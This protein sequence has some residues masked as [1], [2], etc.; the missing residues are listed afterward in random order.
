MIRSQTCVPLSQMYRCRKLSLA[1]AKAT[2]AHAEPDHSDREDGL[3]GDTRVS[4]QVGLIAASDDT[5]LAKSV[6]YWVTG[7]DPPR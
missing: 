7:V 1:G 5:Q 3:S 2:A 4:C 6:P